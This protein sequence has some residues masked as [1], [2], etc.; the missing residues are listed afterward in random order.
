MLPAVSMDTSLGS[1][2]ID[3]NSTGFVRACL[4]NCESRSVSVI[5]SADKVGIAADGRESAR[6]AAEEKPQG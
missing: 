2:V 5:K 3:H 6:E 1:R 4:S